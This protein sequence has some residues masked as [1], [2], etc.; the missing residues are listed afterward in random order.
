M[1]STGFCIENTFLV[2]LAEIFTQLCLREPK[3]C[4][5]T[6]SHVELWVFLLA[7]QEKMFMF[8]FLAGRLSL[9]Y[10]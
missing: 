10:A 6:G 1:F 7:R 5:F 2:F 4:L 9:I 8:M 3:K